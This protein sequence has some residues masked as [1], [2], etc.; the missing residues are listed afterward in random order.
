MARAPHFGLYA[1]GI[2]GQALV[3]VGELPQVG[4]YGAAPRFEITD[5]P[6]GCLPGTLPVE[7][8]VSLRG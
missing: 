5:A 3:L 1:E 7:D 8:G 2:K 4:G 6:L